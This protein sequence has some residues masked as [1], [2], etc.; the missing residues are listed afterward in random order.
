MAEIGQSHSGQKAFLGRKDFQK[1]IESS[2]TL[3]GY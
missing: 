1:G 2:K 3:A